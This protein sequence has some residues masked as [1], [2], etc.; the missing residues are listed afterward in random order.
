MP[1]EPA[2]L[3]R[4]RPLEALPDLGLITPPVFR[5]ERGFLLERW[6]AEAYAALGLPAFVQDNHSRSHGGV[7]RG[8]HFQAPPHAQGKLVGVIRGRVFDVAVDLRCGSPTFGRWAG[9]E[10]DGDE[11]A[12]LWVPPGFAH[13]FLALSDVADVL[14]KLTVGH[15]PGAEGGLAWDDPEVGIA[16]PLPPGVQPTLSAKD[17]SQP[18][19]RDVASPFA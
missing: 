14:Y 8:L 5:D 17:A 9:T 2:S 12:W 11:P 16:W 7:L 15:A 19:L 10:L 13:G 18:R 1:P 3:A 4:L 6:N